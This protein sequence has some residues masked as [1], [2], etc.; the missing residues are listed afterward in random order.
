M[1]AQPCAIAGYGSD[2]A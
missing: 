2:V 1:E